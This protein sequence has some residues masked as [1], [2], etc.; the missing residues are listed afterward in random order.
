VIAGADDHGLCTGL[1]LRT[2]DCGEAGDDR[3]HGRGSFHKIPAGAFYIV[4]LATCGR[5]VRIAH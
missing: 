1:I 2:D 4:I 3:A 5:F